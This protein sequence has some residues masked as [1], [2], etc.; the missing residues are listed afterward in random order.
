VTNVAKK[1]VL[2]FDGE[3]QSYKSL[4]H[5][6]L[7]DEA[8]ELTEKLQA[9]GSDSLIIDQQH[10]HRALSFHKCKPCRKC[11][12]EQT[13]KRRESSGEAEGEEPFAAAA[14]ESESD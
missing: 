10:Q 12:E 8:L 14:E 1:V 3:S 6:L 5:N 13:A 11:A 9:E 2:S 4:G 7:P